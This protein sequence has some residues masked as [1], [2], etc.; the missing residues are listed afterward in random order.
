MF[1]HLAKLLSRVTVVLRVALRL[2]AGPVAWTAAVEYL[3]APSAAMGRDIPVGFLAGGPH[4][5]YLLDA[6]NAG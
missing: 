1:D 5:V 3:M 2:W 6:F 4:A